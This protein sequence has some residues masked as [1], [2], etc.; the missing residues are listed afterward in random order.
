M[1]VRD[2]TCGGTG[3]GGAA[4]TGGTTTTLRSMGS[5][6]GSTTLGA[7]VIR[8]GTLPPFATAG[9]SA[10]VITVRLTGTLCCNGPDFSDCCD[11]RGV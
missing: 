7:A 1:V 3:D 11:I 10:S 9:F 4:G 2:A 6:A 8:F 5:F